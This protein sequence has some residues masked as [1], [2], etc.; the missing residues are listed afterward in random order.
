MQTA[1]TD[2]KLTSQQQLL[3]PPLLR[4]PPA[5][6]RPTDNTGSKMVNRLVFF[7]GRF[8]F[9]GFAQKNAIFLFLG[10]M[11]FGILINANAW[12]Q[13]PVHAFAFYLNANEPV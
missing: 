7:G 12:A 2:C 8:V 4:S 10:Q 3:R 9:L 5:P 11:R 6:A 13:I 1:D